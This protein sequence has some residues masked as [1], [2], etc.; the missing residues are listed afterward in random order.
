MSSVYLMTSAVGQS[1]R[2]GT[3]A[4]FALTVAGTT[5]EWALAVRL[6]WESC[7]LGTRIV[8]AVMRLRNSLYN[9]LLENYTNVNFVKIE[10]NQTF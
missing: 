3:L 5:I 9:L 10:L 6:A 2:I 4:R 8:N 1:F 7:Q